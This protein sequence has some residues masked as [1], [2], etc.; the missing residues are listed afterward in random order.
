MLCGNVHTIWTFFLDP[1]Q[2]SRGFIRPSS[3]GPGCSDSQCLNRSPMNANPGTPKFYELGSSRASM[4]GQGP[5][6]SSMYCHMVFCSEAGEVKPG[7]T[8]QSSTCCLH[9]TCKPLSVLRAAYL[10]RQPIHLLFTTLIPLAVCYWRVL[11]FALWLGRKVQV[12]LQE[13][14]SRLRLCFTI[15]SEK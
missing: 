2:A 1:E 4:L 5:Y 12:A 9:P 3:D 14:E 7:I 15:Q 6:R 11:Q 8:L 13:A 10:N